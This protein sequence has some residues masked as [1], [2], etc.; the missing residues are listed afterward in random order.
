MQKFKDSKNREWML[1]LTIGRARAVKEQTG[2]DLLQPESGMPSLPEILSDEYRVA[3]IL[4]VLLADEFV[5]LGVDAKAVLEQDWDGV[6]TRRAYDALLAELTSFFEGRGQNA[7][8]V[9]VRKTHEA[10]AEALLIVGERAEALDPAAEVRK[11][12]AAQLTASPAVPPPAHGITS[13]AQPDASALTNP[14]T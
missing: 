1:S 9:I 5:R 7:R 8:A 6:T 2:I 10:L 14:S 4:E 13:G 11:T 12:A 3:L